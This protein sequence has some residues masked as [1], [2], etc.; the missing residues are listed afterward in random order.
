MF[1]LLLVAMALINLLYWIIIDSYYF[2]VRYIDIAGHC[3]I[4]Y[5]SVR[6]ANLKRAYKKARRYANESCMAHE[7]I[8]YISLM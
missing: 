8:D 7:Y 1:T 5:F 3:R 4:E 6:A 2:K